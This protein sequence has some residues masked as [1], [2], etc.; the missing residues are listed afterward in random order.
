MRDIAIILGI[1]GIAAVWRRPRWVWWWTALGSVALEVIHHWYAGVGQY[2]PVVGGVLGAMLAFLPDRRLW[3]F[4]RRYQS[5]YLFFFLYTL[6]VWISLI[7]SIDRAISLRYALGVPAIL[8]LSALVLP[9]LIDRGQMTAQDLLKPM[10]ISGVLLTLTAGAAALEFH[11]GF[12]V[13]VGH[14]HLLAWE[15]P[16]ANKNTLGM[17]LMFS[18]TASF[19]LFLDNR[20]GS[21]RI[22]YGLGFVVTLMGVVLSYARTS[23]IATV[24]GLI[25]LV[26]FRYRKRGVW[27]VAG[28]GVVLGGAA[29]LV[30][31]VHKW[32]KLWAH[33]LTGR[34]GLWIAALKAARLH[35]F[36]G[37]GA[38]NSPQ[39]LYP[40]VPAIYRG[41]TPSDSILR[42]LVELGG[43]GLVV[44]T[45]IILV[46]LY[47]VFWVS[48]MTFGWTAVA[49]GAVLFASLVEQAAESMFLG[50]VFF[51]DLFFTALVGTVWML[52][53][54]RG[55]RRKL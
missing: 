43:V 6:A 41:L 54:L 50:G 23:W 36:F 38:G 33:G 45:V 32:Q 20:V 10:I 9:Y 7:V 29:V 28:G 48:P 31:G 17:L 4:F 52:P 3:E 14:H 47:R 12:S 27:A 30:T 34:T 19:A 1:I 53:V 26:I 21:G 25:L 37:V 11:S 22:L 2:F 55:T 51:G 39:A 40:F 8:W 16:F 35:P 13:P 18:A 24:V 44:W 49:L 46:A 42:T 5:R 15:W